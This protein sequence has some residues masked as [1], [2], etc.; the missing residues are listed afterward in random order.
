MIEALESARRLRVYQLK[1]II[2]GM[3]A[4][5][6]HGLAAR[7]ELHLGQAVRFVDF[8]DGQMRSGEII[9]AKDIKATVLEPG[10]KRTS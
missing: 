10:T 4:D 9:A 1:A 5:P 7:A 8:R 2:E 6:R 3:L